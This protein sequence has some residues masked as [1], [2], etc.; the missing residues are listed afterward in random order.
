MAFFWVPV[1]EY[2]NV[3]T[4]SQV[5]CEAGKFRRQGHGLSAHETA[6]VALMLDNNWV[7]PSPA[8][9]SELAQA[10]RFVTS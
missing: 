5:E 7:R 2:A 3:R 10:I 8:L 6:A 9:A 4:V 1:N